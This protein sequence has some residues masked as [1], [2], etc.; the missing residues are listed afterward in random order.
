MYVSYKTVKLD[1]SLLSTQRQILQYKK[2]TE[3]LQDK[4]LIEILL[5][6]GL[7]D[8]QIQSI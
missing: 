8:N 4:R 1:N 6:K 5:Y 3:I 2:M 7:T